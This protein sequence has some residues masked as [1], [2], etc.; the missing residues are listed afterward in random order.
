M[1]MTDPI[2]DLLTRIRN[3]QSARKTEVSLASSRVKRAIV[4][5]LKD[6][7][8]VSDFRVGDDA[9]K[10]TLTIELKYYE[11]RPVIDRLERVSRPGLRIYRGKNELPKVLGGLGTVIVSTPR[12]VMT[13]REARATGQ[14]GEVLC[15]VA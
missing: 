13:D 6:E 10:S 14:G 7:G 2:A 8:Y 4:K 3:A 11:G 15:I 9:G 1:S 5:V 12:G